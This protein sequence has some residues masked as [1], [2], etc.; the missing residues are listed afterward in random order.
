MKANRAEA[1]AFADI[2]EDV[3]YVGDCNVDR[4]NLWTATT[5]AYYVALEL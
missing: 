3:Y 4:G 1:E 2:A 5:S